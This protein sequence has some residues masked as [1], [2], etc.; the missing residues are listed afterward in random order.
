MWHAF[1]ISWLIGI[2]VAIILTTGSFIHKDEE[3]KD[4]LL[5]LWTMF[6]LTGWII[7]IYIIMVYAYKNFYKKTI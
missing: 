1:I 2:L 6:I 7:G 4:N 3:I 5:L